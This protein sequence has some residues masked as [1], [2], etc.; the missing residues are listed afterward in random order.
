LI[1]DKLARWLKMKKFNLKK[2]NPSLKESKAD[3]KPVSINEIVIH[4]TSQAKITETNRVNDDLTKHAQNIERI[5]KETQCEQDVD[6]MREE[7]ELKFK[8]AAIVLDRFFLCVS[9]VYAVVTFVALVIIIPNVYK[10]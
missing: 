6:K 4:D 10:S 1:C 2:E 9:S 7:Q 3:K 5:L 8:F